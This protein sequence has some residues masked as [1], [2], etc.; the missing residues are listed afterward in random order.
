MSVPPQEITIIAKGATL[1]GHLFAPET[2]AK[3]ALVIHGA[4]G[5]P[6]RFYAGFASWAATRGVATLTYDYRD[7]GASQT[8]PM[9]D[10]NATFTDW[11]IHDQTAAETRLADL[12]P[13]GS[14]MSLGHSLGGL[15][16]PFRDYDPRV[17]QITTVGAG[18]THL[19]DHPLTYLPQVTAFWY[20]IG[21]LAT[22][23]VGYLPG[24]RLMLGEDLPA[25]VYWQW[26]RWCTSRGFYKADIG[27]LI[28]APDYTRP[29][30]PLR[31]LAMAD[32]PMV[33]PVSVRRYAS[34]FPPERVTFDTLDPK[35]FGLKSLRHIEPFSAKNATVW[36]RFL[37][38]A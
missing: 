26:R 34:H 24:K 18:F 35:D 6:Q 37:G 7:F 30:P 12:A 21:P 16:V 3:A 20:L 22:K 36:P 10:S 11:M 27:R 33:P 17:T 14:L 32:D 5:V 19:R 8:S 28:P 2:A 25:D 31:M 9:R 15:G 38:E 29:T 4:T 13:T 23:L 1:T